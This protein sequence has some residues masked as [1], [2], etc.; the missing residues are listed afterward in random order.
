[1]L[2]QGRG[3]GPFIHQN[4]AGRNESMAFAENLKTN[5]K[6]QVIHIGT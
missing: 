5:G 1:M 4:H 6:V 2:G 3:F